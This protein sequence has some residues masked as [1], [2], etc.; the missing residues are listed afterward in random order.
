MSYHAPIGR[1]EKKERNPLQE[2]L[3]KGIGSS[4]AMQPYKAE[5]GIKSRRY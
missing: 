1:K 5:V 2:G 3:L 4:V